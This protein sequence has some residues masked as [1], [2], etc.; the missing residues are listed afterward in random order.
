MARIPRRFVALR[1]AKRHEV[2]AHEH[3][4]PV[5]PDPHQVIAWILVTDQVALLLGVREGLPSGADDDGLAQV[6]NDRG[7]AVRPP[8]VVR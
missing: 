4:Q 5:V 6:H 1:V 7:L 3:G 2:V 8:L